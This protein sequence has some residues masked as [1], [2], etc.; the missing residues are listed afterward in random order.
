MRIVKKLS[1][2]SPS[3]LH[4][5]KLCRLAVCTQPLEWEVM[6][7]PTGEGKQ[8]CAKRQ[9]RGTRGSVTHPPDAISDGDCLSC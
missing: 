3:Q 9:G 1:V 6:A 5:R 7:F 2:G 8:L 4:P